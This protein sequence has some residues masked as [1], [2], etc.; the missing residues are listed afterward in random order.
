MHAHRSLPAD[1]PS[2]V[3]RA[4]SEDIGT[5]DLTAGL[6]P[7]NNTSKAVII[8]REPA[9]FCG[10]AWFNE[11]FLQLDNTIRIDWACADADQIKPDQT[12]CTV[13]GPTRVLLSGERTALN[14]LQLLSGTA[15]TTHDYVS[16]LG[17]SKTKLL[18]TRKTIP[19][20]RTAQKY[21]VACG[22]GMNHR[23]GLYDAILIKENHIHATGSIRAAVTSAKSLHRNIEVEVE[24][25]EELQQA[26]DAGADT[27]LLDNFNISTMKE[28]V[29]LNAGRVSLEVSGGVGK[30]IL[31]AIASTGV[32]YISVGA[33][34]K[35][36]RAIDFSM[37]ILT[38]DH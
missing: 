9:V 15:T 30:D 25:L 29:K 8:C 20:L 37:K 36:V 1:I 33:L 31:L 24:T 19:G 4:L 14:F 28:A 10:Q 23:M 12:V 21:A 13:H 35:H 32:D 5:G 7:H 38:T 2:T 27:V 34:T 11:V 22:G 18:D 17:N 16:L 6:I 26:I 3:R